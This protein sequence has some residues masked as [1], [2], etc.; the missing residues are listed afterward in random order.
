MAAIFYSKHTGL[1]KRVVFDELRSDA[2]LLE[3]YLPQA[4]ESV[5]CA[6]YSFNG[7]ATFDVAPMQELVTE[8]TG[9]VPTEDAQ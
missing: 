1:V 9:L 4:D 5:L 8:T 3:I 7:M 6:D 2:A